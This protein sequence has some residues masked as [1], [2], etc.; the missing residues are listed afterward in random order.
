MA[1]PSYTKVLV[2]LLRVISW[3]NIVLFVLSFTSAVLSMKVGT[4]VW[5][6]GSTKA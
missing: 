2:A 1:G 6:G 5:C 3:K 4:I